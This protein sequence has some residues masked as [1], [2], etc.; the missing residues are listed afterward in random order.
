MAQGTPESEGAHGGERR[1]R[2]PLCHFAVIL[3]R[4]HTYPNVPP[5]PSIVTPQQHQS[6]GHALKALVLPPD[7]LR[8]QNKTEKLRDPGSEANK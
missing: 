6:T 7:R 5:A 3:E 1:G 8:A 4:T 2:S